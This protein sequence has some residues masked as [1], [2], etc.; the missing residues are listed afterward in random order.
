[1]LFLQSI[2]CNQLVV[3]V[4]NTLL[5]LNEK[6]L[7]EQSISCHYSTV[8]KAMFKCGMIESITNEIII[9]DFNVDAVKTFLIVSMII[10]FV[11]IVLWYCNR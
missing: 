11:S 1:M 8:F 5:C 2:T 9:T 3:V 7:V 4:S 6:L 10:L